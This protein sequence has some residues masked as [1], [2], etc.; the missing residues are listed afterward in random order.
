MVDVFL[1]HYHL[2]NYWKRWF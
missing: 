2:R 1:A